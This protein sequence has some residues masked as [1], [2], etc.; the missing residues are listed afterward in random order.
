MSEQ[1]DQRE[2]RLA[3]LKAMQEQGQ[4]PF[5]ETKYERTHLAETL[6]EHFEE[7]EGESVTVAG[8]LMAIREHGKSAFADLA[9]G[10]GR[11]QLFARLNE[12]GE[13][14]FAQFR[15]LDLGDIVGARGSLMKTR[16]GEVSVLLEEFTLLAKSLRPL[17][18]KFHGLTDVET[19]YRQR[20][21]DLIVNE[22]VREVFEKRARMIAR[23]RRSLDERGF[24]EF[25]TPSL[26][27]IY[28]GANARPF[29]THHNALDMRLYMRIAPELYLKRLLVGGFEKVYEIG[30]MF[31]NEGV[32]ARHNPEFT[33]LEAYQA[34]ADHEDMMA[35]FEGLV[36]ELAEEV[37][38][39]K[40]FTYRGNEIDVAPPWRRLPLLDAVEE[41]TGVDF[42]EL[43]SD[44]EARAACAELELGDTEADTWGALLDKAFDR[45][46]Q[47][48][49]IQPTFVVDYPVAI[50]PLAKS[51]PDEPDTTFRFEPFIGGEE[52]GNAFAELND[53]LDQRRR[54]EQQ[55]AAREAGDEEAHPLD[56]DFVTALEY[57]M[58]PAGGMG[59]GV[60]RLAMLLLDAA[61]LRE[62][63]A[64]PLL[65]ARGPG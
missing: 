55:A 27:P 59:K 20:Y 44:E 24:V 33:M 2:A 52:L 10:S 23:L 54:F 32:D 47:P 43:A 58:P 65:R 22:E 6:Q 64:F 25:S 34:Y 35:L 13:E 53:P 5:A 37:C 45:Y 36:A 46:V 49:L 18:E 8:R 42:K 9:D 62:I 57:G 50:S 30:P 38:G 4:D 3:K 17:P 7:L 40:T 12:L 31:R 41:A 19:R 48:E 15:D 14:P 60:D 11:V 21:L 63:I 1:G 39:G 16:S 61:N 26:Q 29:T 51:K 28:G 56:E